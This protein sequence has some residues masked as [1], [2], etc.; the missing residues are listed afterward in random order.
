MNVSEA[1]HEKRAKHTYTNT[2]LASPDQV[3]R[4]QTLKSLHYIILVIYNAR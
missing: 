2:G 1:K 4:S 3:W